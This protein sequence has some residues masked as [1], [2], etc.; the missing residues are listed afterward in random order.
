[1]STVCFDQGIYYMFAPYFNEEDA[2]KIRRKLV[3]QTKFLAT[4]TFEYFKHTYNKIPFPKTIKE[5]PIVLKSTFFQQCQQ[6]KFSKTNCPTNSNDIFPAKQTQCFG[7]QMEPL[8][9]ACV[10]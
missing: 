6:C 1:M 2:P 8:I 10:V 4:A 5:Q 3:K 7:L 9:K